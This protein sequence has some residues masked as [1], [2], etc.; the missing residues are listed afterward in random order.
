[1]IIKPYTRNE[2]IASSIINRTTADEDRR[3]SLRDAFDERVAICAE[4]MSEADA[5]RVAMDEIKAKI[6][7]KP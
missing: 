7:V 1:M 3:T 2:W 5:E 4:T 6:G